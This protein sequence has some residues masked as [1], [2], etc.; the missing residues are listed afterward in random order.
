MGIPVATWYGGDVGSAIEDVEKVVEKIKTNKYDKKD[1]YYIDY[2]VCR[3]SYNIKKSLKLFIKTWCY[4]IISI[5]Y[6][7]D[8]RFIC[9]DFLYMIIK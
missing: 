8:V 9:R 7:L 1:L 5:R 4:Y 6:K 3:L 2:L